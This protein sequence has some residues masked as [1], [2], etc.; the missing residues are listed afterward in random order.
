[1]RHDGLLFASGWHISGDEYTQFVVDE[2]IARYHADGLEATL[3]Y[4]SSPDSVDAQ[5]YAPT[6]LLKNMTAMLTGRQKERP[7]DL[8]IPGEQRHVCVDRK[9]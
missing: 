8:A 2:A 1:M 7:E 5:F 3:A 4:Y 9:I 6:A